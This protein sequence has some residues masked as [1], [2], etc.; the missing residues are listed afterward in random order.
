MSRAP[1]RH[2]VVWIDPR[3]G[4]VTGGLFRW[5]DRAAAPAP[6]SQ[7]TGYRE[8]VHAVNSYELRRPASEEKIICTSRPFYSLLGLRRK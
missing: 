3:D 5:P 8:G 7:T 2:A 1:G 4:T 6:A